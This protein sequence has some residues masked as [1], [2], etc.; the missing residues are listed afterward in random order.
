MNTYSVR[1]GDID[2]DV[3]AAGYR[4]ALL[5]ALL[6]RREGANPG[7]MAEVTAKSGDDQEPYY[8]PTHQTTS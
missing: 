6:T 1:T 4:E 3:T 7:V 5:V 2:T 8:L